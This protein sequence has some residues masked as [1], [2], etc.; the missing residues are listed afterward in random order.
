MEREMEDAIL[1]EVDNSQ[2]VEILLTCPELTDM[3]YE[4]LHLLYLGYKETEIVKH[5]EVTRQA[6]NRLKMSAFK[7]IREK[8]RDANPFRDN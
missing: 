8:F 3:E 5:M 4:V 7:K 1:D 2:L 6:V